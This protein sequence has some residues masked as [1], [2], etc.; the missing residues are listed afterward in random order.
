LYLKNG[1]EVS[2]SDFSISIEDLAVLRGD[3]IFEAIKIHQGYP[4]GVERHLER[5]QRSAKKVFFDNIDF[6]EIKKNIYKVAN[7]FEN[8]YVRT[9]ILRDS[10]DGYNVFC[11]HQP[12]VNIPEYFTLETQKAFWHSSG[13]Y[14]QDEAFNLGTKSTSYGMNISHTRKA[15]MNGYTDALL[16][17]KSGE[18]LEGPTF[19]FGWISDDQ[20]FVPK[21]ELGILDSITRQ[22]LLDFGREGILPVKEGLI[23]IDKL[24]TIQGAFILSTAKHGHCI[25]RIDDIE[26]PKHELINQIKKTFEER[27]IKERDK[28]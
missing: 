27:V 24:N 11:F 18:V 12:P 23:H 22:Y 8:G 10:K 14:S 6:D 4:F 1:I 7:S 19:T 3:G 5:F 25:S 9:L 28:K 20:I 16:I 2:K 15:E 13:D 26:L 21:L 17:G